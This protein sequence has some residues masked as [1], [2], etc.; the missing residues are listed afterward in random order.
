MGIKFNNF[1]I[2]EKGRATFNVPARA[3]DYASERITFGPAGSG[4]Q[5]Q[6]FQGFSALC[7]GPFLA[8]AVVELWLPRI[9]DGGKAASALT[10]ADYSLAGTLLTAAGLGSVTPAGC[11]T[12]GQI[13]VKSGGSQGQLTI[14]G[15]AA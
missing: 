6:A 4:D 9:A 13:R 8:S 14:S 7:E 11:W 2:R 15:T 5:E 10:D 1:T 3:G 12:G